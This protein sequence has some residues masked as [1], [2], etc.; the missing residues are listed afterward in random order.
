MGSLLKESYWLMNKDLH[1][2]ANK[3]ALI[4]YMAWLSEEHY[5]AGW[6]Q[7][8][9]HECR[10]EKWGLDTPQ[11]RTLQLLNDNADGWWPESYEE[12]QQIQRG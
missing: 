5:C 3:E 4:N 2:D 8:W 9:E 7:G 1:T 10:P 6:L 11:G 12:V